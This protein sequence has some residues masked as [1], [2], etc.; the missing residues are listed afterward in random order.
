M[1]KGKIYEGVITAVDFPNKGRIELAD[2]GITVTV[3]NGVPGQR[4]KFSINKLRQ[5]K[6]E[7]KILEVIER[8]P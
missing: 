8:S 4:V 7:G 1:K 5:G 2:E 6:A 3:K